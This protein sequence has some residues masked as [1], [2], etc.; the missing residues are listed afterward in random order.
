MGNILG[1]LLGTLAGPLLDVVK[2]INKA[3]D[4]TFSWVMSWVKALESE[5]MAG[6]RNAENFATSVE[7]Y[8]ISVYRYAKSIYDYVTVAFKGWILALYADLK[9]YADDAYSYLIGWIGWLKN[10]L[11]KLGNDILSWIMTNIWNPLYADIRQAWNWITKYGPLIVALVTDPGKLAS[12]LGKYLWSSW[13]GLI[14]Q[15]SK[16]IAR[17]LLHS[18]LGMTH[19]IATVV[20]DIIAGML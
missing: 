18:M 1:W 2:W 10:S 9:K 8:A 19:E 3:F 14:T 4:A 5:F 7:T 15:Y 12:Y 11:T 16:P 17:W 6:L 13:I 20:E